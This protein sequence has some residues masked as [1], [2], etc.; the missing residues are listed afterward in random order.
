MFTHYNGDHDTFATFIEHLRG[1]A[2]GRYFATVAMVDHPDHIEQCLGLV[3]DVLVHPFTQ[4]Q[5]EY[6]L[7]THLRSLRLFRQLVNERDDLACYQQNIFVEQELVNKI[8]SVQCEGQLVEFDN[9]RCQITANAMFHG[10]F[11]LTQ[12]GPAGSIY[13]L[14]AEASGNGL[15][16]TMASIPMFSVFKAMTLKGLPVGSIASELN[17]VLP[18]NIPD[19]MVVSATVAELNSS[20]DQLTVWSGGM[21]PAAIVDANGLFK[22]T[23]TSVNRPLAEIEEFDFSPDVQVYNLAAKDKVVFTTNSLA[24]A[25]NYEQELFG[26]DRFYRLFD[27]KHSDCFDLVMQAHAQFTEGAPQY[28]DLALLTLECDVEKMPA[29]KTEK[30]SVRPIPWHLDVTLETDDLKSVSPVPQIAKLLANAVGL[31]VHQDFIS[32]I[33]SEL[34]NNALEHGLLG[35]SSEMKQSEDGF[36]EYYTERE[37]RL[38]ELNEG[39][40]KINISL[41]QGK[42]VL[43]VHDS[44]KG[45]DY[46]AL[47][48][49]DDENAYGRGMSII[50]SVCDSFEYSHNGS[51]VTVHYSVTEV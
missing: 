24:H 16:A 13:L 1:D 28:S 30:K 41:K 31:D 15:P 35:L 17:R 8:F 22:Q 6:K 3:D 18:K 33:L 40:V 39:W 51:K 19:D 27:G 11:L 47:S 43:S 26:K 21:L 5:V 4:T 29:A 14:I 9:V 44:G 25:S 48:Q 2:K 7:N 32:T 12:Q 10:S 38:A 34:Y 37:I 20:A 45:F 49:A 42:V 50:N 36:L 23:V 46:H